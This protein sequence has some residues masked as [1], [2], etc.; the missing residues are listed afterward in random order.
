MDG[1][2]LREVL[3]LINADKP[4][5][6]SGK[7]INRAKRGHIIVESALDVVLHQNGLLEI[8]ETEVPLGKLYS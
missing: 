1:S 7:A 6:L 4:H 2:G 8:S 3:D 5:L